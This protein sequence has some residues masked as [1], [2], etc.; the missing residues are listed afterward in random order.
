MGVKIKNG[1]WFDEAPVKTIRE[2]FEVAGSI[3]FGNSRHCDTYQNI[4]DAIEG[5]NKKRNKGDEYDAY[6]NN[7]DEI[8]TKVTV[9]TEIVK[10]IKS[11]DKI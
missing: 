1:A 8:I 10:V 7:Q 11:E 6:W 3:G 4:D 2:H 9:I 5:N